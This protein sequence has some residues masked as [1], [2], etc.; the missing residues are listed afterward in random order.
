MAQFTHAA[1]LR[2]ARTMTAMDVGPAELA[3][4]V[5]DSGLES[6][7]YP[8][9]THVPVGTGVCLVAQRDP[10]TMAKEVAALDHLSDGRFEFGVGAEHQGEFIAFDPI[11]HGQNPDSPRSTSTVACPASKTTPRTPSC[12]Q[13]TT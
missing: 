9:H 4:A 12:P 11:G 1:M 6:L 2:A 5:E 10:I 3:R 7:F 13:W 8:E